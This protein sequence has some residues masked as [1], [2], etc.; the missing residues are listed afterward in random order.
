MG[1]VLLV[2]VQLNGPGSE[3]LARHLKAPAEDAVNEL[4]ADLSEP[5]R[6]GLR[7]TSRILDDDGGEL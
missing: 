1:T 6:R 7:V 5:E 2:E 3:E 4:I